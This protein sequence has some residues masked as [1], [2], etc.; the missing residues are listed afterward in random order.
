[1]GL[2][3]NTYPT[4]TLEELSFLK[5]RQLEFDSI[6][7]MFITRVQESP[8]DIYVYYYDQ[9]ITYAQTNERANKVANYLKDKGVKKGD[10]VSVM[11][12]NSPEC[13]YTI[14]RGPEDRS[15]SRGS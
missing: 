10:V 9:A 7:E 1:M 8:D 6:A 4:V 5:G 14:V 11:I 12:L 13:Y 15:R 2:K 3:T